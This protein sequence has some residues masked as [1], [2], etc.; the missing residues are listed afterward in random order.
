MFPKEDIDGFE[1]YWRRAMGRKTLA[2]MLS[3]GSSNGSKAWD[4]YP[5]PSKK[6]HFNPNVFR[7]LLL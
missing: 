7:L 6:D 2:C 3:I 1:R 4:A 5:V